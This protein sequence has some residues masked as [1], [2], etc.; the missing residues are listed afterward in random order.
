[1]TGLYQ[2]PWDFSLG[3]SLVGRQ[4]YPRIVYDEVTTNG[5]AGATDVLLTQPGDLKFK[6][7][8]EFDVRA[9]KDF[10]IMNRVGITLSADL[11]NVPNQRTILQREGLLF[12]DGDYSGN[13]NNI[14][15]MQSPRVWR[16]GAKI[17][18]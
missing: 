12:F 3:A 14:T 13:G 2:L 9:A 1:M 15:E 8:Y 5:A 11:F 7:V 16:F 17:T 6:N 10:R 4:G 18:Y